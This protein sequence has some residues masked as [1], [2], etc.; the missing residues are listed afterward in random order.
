MVG[1]SEDDVR[2]KASMLYVYVCYHVIV[3]MH[4]FESKQLAS[5]IGYS[6]CEV[7]FSKSYYFCGHLGVH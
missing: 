6:P 5:P 1:V 3:C 7:F 2:V 4:V